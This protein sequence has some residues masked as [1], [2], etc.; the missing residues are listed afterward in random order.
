MSIRVQSDSSGTA[1]GARRDAHSDIDFTFAL[2][3]EMQSDPDAQPLLRVYRPRPTVAFS[4]RESLMPTF[5]AAS[6]AALAHGS[7]PV[8]RLAGGRAVAYDDDCL[9]IDLLTPSTEAER[10]ATQEVFDVAAACIRSVLV[11]LGVDARVGE[12]P[13]EYCAGA[14][15][16]NARGRVKLV[17]IAQRV[18]RGARLVTASLVLGHAE[19]LR[20]VVDDVYSAM[21]LEWDPATFGTLADEGVRLSPAELESAITTALASRYTEWAARRSP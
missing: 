21:G 12:V 11:D 1:A 6:D 14:H 4:R 20:N 2:L 17:G 13:G 10:F 7:T 19:R 5:A 18:T 9:V 16:V 8:I 3:R 15:S